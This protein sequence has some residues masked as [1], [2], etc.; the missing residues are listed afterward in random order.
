M[1]ST[2]AKELYPGNDFFQQQEDPEI[3]KV[4]WKIGEVS[5]I[6]GLSEQLI[7]TYSSLLNLKVSRFANGHR[8]FDQGDIATLL[9]MVELMN[10]GFTISGAAE[11]V[12]KFEKIIIA[13]S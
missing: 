6:V 7:R 4:A 11:H 8:R 2:A 12:N 13:L 5:E 3:K 1:N 9:C 10:R